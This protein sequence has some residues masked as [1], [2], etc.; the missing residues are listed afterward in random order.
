MKALEFGIDEAGRGPVIGPM[1][2]AG[3][4]LDEKSRREL[5]NLGVKDSK[6][7]T[8]KRREFLE[9]EIKR[10]AEFFKVIKIFPKE[11]DGEGKERIKL[12]E[13]ESLACSKI[14]NNL[15]EHSKK[16]NI[17]V[18]CPSVSIRKWEDSLRVQIKD[19]TNLGL[20]CEHKAD[21]NHIVVS[22]ASILAKCEREKE[23]KKLKEKY[24]KEI[25][26]G[27]CSD[28]TSMKFLKKNILKYDKEGI[29]RKSWIT[30]KKAYEEKNQI[31]L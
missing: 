16:I 15:G 9:E 6:Q 31:K 24:G 22:A 2:V 5:K 27:Y 13:I 8:Q 30:W 10:R 20:S 7:L 12:N 11:I 1:V 23:M 25:G 28:S 14:I 29:F 18:D 21:Q 26:S 4:L 17:F 19:F 3:C